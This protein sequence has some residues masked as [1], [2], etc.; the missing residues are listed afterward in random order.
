MTHTLKEQI[1]ASPRAG[2]S[3][4]LFSEDGVLKWIPLE[5]NAQA[6]FKSEQI[7]R[8]LGFLGTL[9]RA[10]FWLGRI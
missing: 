3:R 10:S 7:N 2:L 1:P 8:L 5:I 4:S 9:T 6:Y